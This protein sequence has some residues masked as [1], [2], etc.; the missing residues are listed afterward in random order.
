MMSFQDVLLSQLRLA[1][2]GTYAVAPHCWLQFA[3]R[4]PSEHLPLQNL[5]TRPMIL[6]LL[7]VP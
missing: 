6:L 7:H 4:A 3:V 2:L 5:L 1:K